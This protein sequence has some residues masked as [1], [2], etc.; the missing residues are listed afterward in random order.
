VLA[1][2]RQSKKSSKKMTQSVW[3]PG[4]ETLRHCVR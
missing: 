2:N 3:Q 4:T 1:G